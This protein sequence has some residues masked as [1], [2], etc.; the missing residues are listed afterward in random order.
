[1]GRY[2]AILKAID[3]SFEY[4]SGKD[5]CRTDKLD[6]KLVSEI[7]TYVQD[8]PDSSFL[9]DETIV[10]RAIELV[11]IYMKH[12]FALSGYVFRMDVK[13]IDIFEPLL[14]KENW[15]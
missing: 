13:M 3:N 8:M 4:L 6:L 2:S 7:A 5:N 10:T 9:I 14:R 1:M 12:F 15:S 11:E